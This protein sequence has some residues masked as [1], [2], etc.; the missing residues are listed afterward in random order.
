MKSNNG[1]SLFPQPCFTMWSFVKPRRFLKP[2]R[3]LSEK[4]FPPQLGLEGISLAT[5]HLYFL[6]ARMLFLWI[7]L[8]NNKN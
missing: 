8:K 3:F 4:V 2:T 1:G 6:F 7:R 5:N